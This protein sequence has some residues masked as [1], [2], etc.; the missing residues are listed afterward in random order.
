MHTQHP[1]LVLHEP[2][3]V[4][5]LLR[6]L[7]R[8]ARAG[9]VLCVAAVRRLALRP[10]RVVGHL[11]GQHKPQSLPGLL[12][13]RCWKL[14]GDAAQRLRRVVWRA[15]RLG[16]RVHLDVL[17]VAHRGHLRGDCGVRGLGGVEGLGLGRILDKIEEQRRVVGGARLGGAAALGVALPAAAAAGSRDGKPARVAT[18]GCLRPS[19]NAPCTP[20]R[21]SASAWR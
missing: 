11:R 14:R 21:P 4:A 12:G 2:A 16:R 20:R 8:I 19:S 18:V 1:S 15:Y 5:L 9:K 13:S 10:A 6:R 7:V 17:L 3:A